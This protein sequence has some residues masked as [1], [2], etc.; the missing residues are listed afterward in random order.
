[1]NFKSMM[2]EKLKE[3]V[4]HKVANNSTLIRDV[5]DAVMDD[6][7]YTDLV[8]D[9]NITSSDIAYEIDTSDILSEITDHMD[10]DDIKQLV[11]EKCDMDAVAG[12]VVSMLPEGFMDDLTR[13]MTDEIVK[14]MAVN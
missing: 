10:M 6:L 2:L 13:Q 12:K 9:L 5:A 11:A 7:N 8:A 14:E 4:A 1:M 3:N